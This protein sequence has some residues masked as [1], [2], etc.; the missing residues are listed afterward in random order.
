M[1]YDVIIVGGG[2]AGLTAAIYATRRAMKTLVI[3]QDIGGQASTTD[4]IEN[5]PGYESITGPELM[6]KF[7]KQAEKTGSEFVFDEVKKIVK[8][9]EIFSVKTA[10]QEYMAKTIIL[11]FGLS[12]RHL[13][14]PGEE[15]LIGRGVTYCAT[16]DGPLFKNK[17]V[18]VVGGGNSGVS[19]ALYLSDIV[20]QVHLLIRGSELKGEEVL[21]SQL[22]GKKNI[23]VV[24][25]AVAKEITGTTKVESLISTDAVDPTKM[26]TFEVDGIFVEIG[27][28]VKA[29]CIKGLVAVDQQSQI[30]ISPNNE[31][32][33]PGIFAAGDVTTVTYK[34]IVVS[35]GEGCKAALQAY[36]YLQQKQGKR[37][38]MIDWKAAKSN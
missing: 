20:S 18:A 37:A 17:R 21:T 13:D 26:R 12:H 4:I 5:Y 2:A 25:N 23:E 10:S 6:T 33:V 31:T 11:A 7:H 36:K 32:S 16:C 27:Y 38:V 22:S 3:S 29:D 34:Q 8:S 15:E 14:I 30:I 24:F 1:E 28:V 35:A 9:G 19:A